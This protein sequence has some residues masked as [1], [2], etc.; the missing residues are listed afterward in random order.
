LIWRGFIWLTNVISSG[1][2]SLLQ[3]L[4]DEYGSKT[5][6]LDFCIFP[7]PT[8]ATSVVEPY[9]SV[10]ASH[11][12]LE[13]TDCAF[14]F[15][16][17]AIYDICKRNLD[18]ER[19]SYKTTNRVIAQIISSM[20]SSLRFPGSLNVDLNEFKTNLVPYPRIHFL[21][22]SLAPIISQKK[23]VRE[24]GTIQE[25][26]SAAF[27]SE[28]MMC[29]CDAKKGKYMAVCMMYRGDVGAKDVSD[30]VNNIKNKSTVQFVD[31][32]PAGFKCG[33]NNQKPTVVPGG[34]LAQTSRS[35]TTLCNT[36]AISDVFARINRKFDLMFTKRAFVH[37]YVGEG[38]EEGEFVEARDDLAALEEDYLE[39]AKDSETQMDDE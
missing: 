15:D 21:T 28:N 29:K 14:I 24:K 3:K 23:A 30:A 34:E 37:W 25:I 10:L 13:N 2:G 19:P 8:V 38:M 11:V 20:T 33:I 22:C 12:L 17:E 39:V 9:N 26:T 35:L 16:N 32:S 7:S 27:E 18:I 6:K 1:F 5:N 31:W 4:T 36:T